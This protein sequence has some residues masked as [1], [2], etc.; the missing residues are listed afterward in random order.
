MR[1][2]EGGEGKRIGEDIREGKEF[3][4]RRRTMSM[5]TYW[6]IGDVRKVG[7]IFAFMKGE[8]RLCRSLLGMTC[9]EQGGMSDVWDK[10]DREGFW[11]WGIVG[12]KGMGIVGNV[13]GGNPMSCVM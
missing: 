12:L 9:C 13:G 1:R 3:G 6:R 2:G 8:D 5:L 11:F 10:C 4:A 7:L